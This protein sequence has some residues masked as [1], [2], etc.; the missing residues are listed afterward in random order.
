MNCYLC[1]IGR[2]SATAQGLEFKEVKDTNLIICESCDSYPVLPPTK[3]LDKFL[4]LEAKIQALQNTLDVLSDTVKYKATDTLGRTSDYFKVKNNPY[5]PK[6]DDQ[7]FHVGGAILEDLPGDQK[8]II[9]R[10]EDDK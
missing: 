3:I 1:G 4:E 6:S 10:E 7:T 2:F 5:S 9:R 8:N